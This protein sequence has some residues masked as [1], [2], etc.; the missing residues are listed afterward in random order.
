MTD[1]EII[2]AQAKFLHSFIDDIHTWEEIA[3]DWP[4]RAD[5]LRQRALDNFAMLSGMEV[6]VKDDNQ[7]WIGGVID[8]KARNA[9]EE[10]QRVS[11]IGA[12]FVR[13]RPLPGKKG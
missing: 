11:I 6:V 8:L 7:P 3:H 5:H 12:G 2:E 10:D 9:D 13:V 4:K 1:A